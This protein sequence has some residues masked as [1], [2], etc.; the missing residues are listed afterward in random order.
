MLVDSHCHIDFPEFASDFEGVLARMR[1]T[2]RRMRCVSASISRNCLGYWKLRGARDVYA[3]VGV[4]PDHGGGEEP[5]KPRLCALA[6]SLR[7][8]PSGRRAWITTEQRATRN[9]SAPAFAPTS[10]LPEPAGN[11][12]SSIPRCAADT[13]AI[14]RRGG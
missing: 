10:Q 9:G 13:L 1:S 6:H 14:M 5:T 7:S 4:H 3:S 11:P 2:R 12:S 8:S